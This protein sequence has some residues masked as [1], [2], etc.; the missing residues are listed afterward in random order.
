MPVIINM[1]NKLITLFLEEMGKVGV[2]QSLV[3]GIFFYLC[4]DFNTYS[5]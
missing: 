2:F 5:T 3:K 1:S 4:Q